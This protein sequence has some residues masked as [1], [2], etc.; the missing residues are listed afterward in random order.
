MLRR[1]LKLRG[2]P[3]SER[4]PSPNIICE[5]IMKQR[6]SRLCMRSTPNTMVT[7]PSTTTHSDAALACKPL[8]TTD[9]VSGVADRAKASAAP[10]AMLKGL[11]TGSADCERDKFLEAMERGLPTGYIWVP[12]DGHIHKLGGGAS[13]TAICGP[14]HIDRLLRTPDGEEWSWQITFLDRD[15][16]L[17][18][19]I[20]S[21]AEAKASPS[22]LGNRLSGR[23]FDLQGTASELCK[24][25]SAIRVEGRGLIVTQS[26]WLETSNEN[27]ATPTAYVQPDGNI[28][29]GPANIDPKVNFTGTRTGNDRAGSLEGWQNS[30]ATLA[31]GNPALV[32]SICVGLSGPLL[33]FSGFGTMGFNFYAKTSSGKS[34]ALK[35]AASCGDDSDAVMQWNGTPSGLALVTAAA[36]DRLLLLDEFPHNPGREVIETLYSIGNGIGRIRANSKVE[37]WRVALLSTSEKSLPEMFAT[38]RNAMPEG[39]SVR[40][41]DIPARSWTYG[42]LETLHGHPDGHAFLLELSRACHEHHGHALPRFVD[43][44]LHSVDMYH[45]M[46]PKILAI[47]RSNIL[48]ALDLTN[49]TAPGQVHRAVERFALVAAA[50]EIAIIKRLLPWPRHTAASAAAE[51]AQLWYKAFVARQ[52]SASPEPQDILRAYFAKN[53]EHFIDL[54]IEQGTDTAQ[55]FGWKDSTF[56]YLQ[57]EVFNADI[58][59]GETVRAVAQRLEEAGILVRGSEARS[60]QYRMPESLVRAR[61]RVYRLRRAAIS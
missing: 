6:N 55:G 24:F 47:C 49:S 26:G 29:L 51:L 50:G 20:A 21:M 31:L 45:S 15:R 33:K 28:H 1:T 40:L 32:F 3:R 56:V 38:S 25:L 54:E 30:V 22:N 41:L 58:A 18:G 44:I 61:P 14:I 12:E 11:V 52:S 34:L 42:L 36:N 27:D 17:R 7:K 10:A 43:L 4:A 57:R 23:G 60:Y 59:A 37:R 46:F 48:K 2:N 9:T 5:M 53:I 39:L 8:P 13:K 16:I 35:A 19:E